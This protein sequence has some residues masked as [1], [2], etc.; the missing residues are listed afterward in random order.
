[1]YVLFQPI[2]ERLEQYLP[3]DPSI[4]AKNVTLI[5]SPPDMQP[6]PCKPLFYDLA[7]NHVLLPD[8]RHKLETQEK[9][10]GISGYLKTWW[11]GGK[12]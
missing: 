5:K 1:L 2:A 6:I 11:G 10:G 9:K 7:G 8:L 3:E 12:K 4:S